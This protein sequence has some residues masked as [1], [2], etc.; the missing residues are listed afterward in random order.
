MKKIWLVFLLV[1]TVSN[2]NA[3]DLILDNA[4]KYQIS[5]TSSSIYIL[6]TT[7]GDIFQIHNSA[8]E[9]KKQRTIKN[10]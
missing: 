9:W 1:I 3:N 6:D 2:L 4:G 5:S 10:N 8:R 7:N